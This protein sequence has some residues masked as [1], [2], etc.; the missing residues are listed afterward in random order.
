MVKLFRQLA[1]ARAEIALRLP[2]RSS[3]QRRE[4]LLPCASAVRPGLHRDDNVDRRRAT[5]STCRAYSALILAEGFSGT[6]L[7]PPHSRSEP[8]I[9]PFPD[10]PLLA[11]RSLQHAEKAMSEMPTPN[12][13]RPDAGERPLRAGETNLRRAQLS[14]FTN[15]VS[16]L[17]ESQWS[18]L[19]VAL[20]TALVVS[21]AFLVDIPAMTDYPNYLARMHV[22]LSNRSTNPHPFYET[23]WSPIPNLAFDLLVPPLA[24]FISVEAATKT[25][26]VVSEILIVTGAVALEFSVKGRHELSGF[27]SPILLYSTSFKVGLLNFERSAVK[28]DWRYEALRS[29]L[30][31]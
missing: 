1:D 25:V 4:Y 7:A 24:Q 10:L 20:L 28:Q 6:S 23:V 5:S 26:F 14:R 17:S 16:R 31:C 29:R 19:A 27:G 18:L 9:N 22:I 21:P 12:S 2:L 30:V 11:L 13:S 8:T 15:S 3:P